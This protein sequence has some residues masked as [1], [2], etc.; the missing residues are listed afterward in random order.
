M[1]IEQLRERTRSGHRR[2]TFVGMSGRASRP[3]RIVRVYSSS[4]EFRF[5]DGEQ[6][7]V[8]PSDLRS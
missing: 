5:D 1:T 8:H 7:R 3:G 2:A 6:S 4:V